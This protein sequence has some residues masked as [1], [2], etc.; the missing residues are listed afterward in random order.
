[1]VYKSA[2]FCMLPRHGWISHY[3][4]Q[5]IC[6]SSNYSQIIVPKELKFSEFDESHPGD[7]IMKFGEDWFVVH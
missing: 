1:M 5:F 2:Q 4:Y 3:N 7:V 6:L